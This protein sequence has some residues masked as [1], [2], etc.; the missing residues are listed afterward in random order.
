MRYDPLYKVALIPPALI[1]P[2]EEN[3]R[4]QTAT[5]AAVLD[6][7][8]VTR[9]SATVVWIR[10]PRLLAPIFEVAKRINAETAWNFDIDV[11]EPLQYTEYGVGDEYGWHCDQ[12]RSPYPDGRVRKFSFSIL[13]NDSF[14]GGAFDLEIHPPN[15][16][17]RHVAFEGLRPGTALFF[18]AD[19]WHRVRP[20]TDGNR[21]S[22]VGWVLGPKF[23]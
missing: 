6:S 5:A 7:D 12:H 15:V 2:I 22:L 9:R 8:G 20:V 10:E 23:R 1:R 4:A 3:A 18:Q 14:Q 21:K 13:L 11:L 19:L 17:V 16:D